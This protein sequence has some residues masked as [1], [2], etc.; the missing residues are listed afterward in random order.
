MQGVRSFIIIAAATGTLAIGTATVARADQGDEL[1]YVTFSA[2]VEVPGV[3]LPAG[4]YTFTLEDST[5]TDGGIV[6]V[7]DRHRS[8]L[9]ATFLSIP[10]QRM[11]TTDKPEVVL[12]KGAPGAPEAVE[13]WFYPDDEVGHKF[14]YPK[15]EAQMIA[16]ANQRA[17]HRAD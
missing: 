17:G 1:T 2:P 14:V 9:Y 12:E 7:F 10:E 3:V 15:A 6:Q 13:A 4:T 8:K 5:G 16:K 11:K